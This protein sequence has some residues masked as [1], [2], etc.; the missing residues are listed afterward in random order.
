VKFRKGEFLQLISL[1][2]RDGESVSVNIGIFW[3][4]GIGWTKNSIGISKNNIGWTKKYCI[5]KNKTD[6]PSLL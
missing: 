4:V 1:L 6:P 5:S 2:S 3:G